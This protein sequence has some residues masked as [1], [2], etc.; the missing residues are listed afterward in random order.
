LWYLGYPDAALAD[1]DHALKDAGEIG[2]AATLMHALLNTSFTLLHCG[3]YATAARKP[4]K[5]SLW[6]TRK[7]LWIGRRL[8]C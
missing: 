8:E 2:Q 4:A 1:A 3:N 7:A 6:L 5:L